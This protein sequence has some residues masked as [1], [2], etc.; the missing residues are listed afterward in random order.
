[1]RSIACCLLV[2]V[3]LWQLLCVQGLVRMTNSMPAQAKSGSSF[4]LLQT[5]AHQ[6]M[7]NKMNKIK[8]K[9]EA[10]GGHE[11]VAGESA[12]EEVTF[13]PTHLAAATVG[14]QIS[15]GLLDGEEVNGEIGAVTTYSS[16]RFVWSGTVEGGSFY[17]SYAA[18]AIVG[19]VYY[20]D[21]ETSTTQGV[22]YEY[23]PL[24][25]AEGS[26][27]LRQVPMSVY[28]EEAEEIHA[29]EEMARMHSTH[30]SGVSQAGPLPLPL[31]GLRHLRHLRG[32]TLAQ[33]QVD[34]SAN[35]TDTGTGTAGDTGVAGDA[36]DA[37]AMG[38]VGDASTDNAILDVMVLITNEGY[39]YFNND[40]PSVLAFMDLGRR[41]L[42][43]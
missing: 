33:A 40:L 10:E 6:K 7:Q 1:M 35:L 3:A 24:D 19:N 39:A 36:G 26:Y 2:V 14:E 13:L 38:T 27:S 37:G 29:H 23:R 22:Q 15:F 5:R 17:L 8:R 21:Q 30:R 42:M 25:R 16:D 31:S 41:C 43:V 28:D 20:P 9:L 4:A 11:G 32:D 18:G 34:L 12:K